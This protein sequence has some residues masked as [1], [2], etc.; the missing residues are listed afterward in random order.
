MKNPAHPASRAFSSPRMCLRTAEEHRL[1]CPNTSRPPE[2]IPN[3][4]L[5]KIS[6]HPL[7]RA[8]ITHN[9]HPWF[10]IAKWVITSPFTLDPYNLFSSPHF[11]YHPTPFTTED[12]ATYAMLQLPST[13]NSVL[14]PQALWHS[15]Q[16]PRAGSQDW[17][18]TNQAPQ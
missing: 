8:F 3:I 9:S 17:K 15:H 11:L 1:P 7:G 10:P 2:H 13:R 12:P 4:I 16:P 5:F 6:K 14:S 18:I